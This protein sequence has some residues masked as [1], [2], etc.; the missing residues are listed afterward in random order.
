MLDL[1][2]IAP[3]ED[4]KYSP[5]LWK[6][7]KKHQRHQVFH[8]L[9]DR[10]DGSPVQLGPMGW[11]RVRN[12]W[13][14]DVDSWFIGGNSLGAIITGQARGHGWA[15]PWHNIGYCEITEEFW[16]AYIARGRCAWD[17]DH[18]LHMIGDERR[19]TTIGGTRRCE[20]CG[21][22]QEARVRKTVRIK[23]ERIW[24]PV[25]PLHTHTSVE[26]AGVAR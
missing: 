19:F 7:L 2:A 13:I 26:V 25:P 11:K 17:P 16:A 18:F 8:L 3:R 12:I 22:W 24:T 4:G 6:W 9:K 14:G 5:F 15:L 20:W 1:S 21:Q 10:I 23:R